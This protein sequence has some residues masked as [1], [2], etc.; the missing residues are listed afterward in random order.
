M[1]AHSSSGCA[2]GI[3]LLQRYD[4]GQRMTE[5]KLFN[6]LLVPDTPSDCCFRKSFYEFLGKVRN[7]PVLY[8]ELDS[9]KP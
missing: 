6:F 2:W 8:G 9:A 4:D 3:K 7:L 5:K 1:Y